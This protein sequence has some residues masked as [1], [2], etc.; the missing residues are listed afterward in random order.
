[1]EF[2]IRAMI[3]EDWE[4]VAA[5]YKEGIDIKIATYQ[6]EVPTYEDWDMS[7]IK[8]CRLVAEADNKIIGWIALTPCSSR[9]VFAGVAEVSIYIKKEYHGN[10]VGEKLLQA[11]ISE[12]EKEG[13][14]TLQSAI[15]DI[16]KASIA[17]HTKVGFRMV[18]Y[19][20]KIA[21][22]L[23]GEWSNLVLMEKRSPV[24]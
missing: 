17:L 20:E 3:K 18:G 21:K 24:I 23:N 6:S 2:I 22:D 8:S 13:F 16:N 19:R 10:H 4:A 9:C 15:I 1:M 5:I 14:W 7:H 12:S 11:I